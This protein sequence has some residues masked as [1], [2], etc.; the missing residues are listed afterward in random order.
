MC[1]CNL[2]KMCGEKVKKVLDFFALYHE[3][4]VDEKTLSLALKYVNR[5]HSV[6]H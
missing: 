6:L 1:K 5:Q 3:L 2:L 4:P